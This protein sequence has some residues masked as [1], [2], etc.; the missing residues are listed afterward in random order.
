MSF[1]HLLVKWLLKL[2][3]SLLVKMAGGTP[4]AIDGYTMDPRMQMLMAQGAKA[5]SITTL[6]PEEA[7][8]ATDEGLALLDAKPRKSVTIVNR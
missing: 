5:P 3:S 2:P 4:I 8:A 6:S 1:Q 7:R